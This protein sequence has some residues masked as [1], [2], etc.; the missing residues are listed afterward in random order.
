MLSLVVSTQPE[1]EQPEGRDH[2]PNYRCAPITE[3]PFDCFGQRQIVP[4]WI[5]PE[6]LCDVVYMSCF[7]RPL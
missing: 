1:L 3:T 6:M 2:R 5:A 4:Q 7:G